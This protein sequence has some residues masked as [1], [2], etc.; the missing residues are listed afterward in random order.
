[1]QKAELEKINVIASFAG[2]NTNRQKKRIIP[3]RFLTQ[4]GETH[5]VTEVRRT[6][7]ERVGDSQHIHFVLE[8]QSGRFFDIVYDSKQITWYLVLEIEDAL[9]HAG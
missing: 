3:H 6:Y 9:L 7:T 1:M 4:R 8:T 2:F 5:V